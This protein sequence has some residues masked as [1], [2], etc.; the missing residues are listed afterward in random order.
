MRTSSISLGLAI[1]AATVLAQQT[2][3]SAPFDLVLSS[4]NSTINGSVL[5][6]CHEGAAIESLCLGGNVAD[7]YDQYNF[8][9]SSQS[10]PDPAL[11]V[12]G[13]LVRTFPLREHRKAR[14][15][16]CGPSLRS[17]P[18]KGMQIDDSIAFNL[19]PSV[20]G[21][22]LTVFKDLGVARWKLQPLVSNGTQHQRDQ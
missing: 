17:L 16:S 11:G 14:C 1:A 4:S 22:I 21:K 5:E 15:S 12:I 7:V 8:N 20:G 10:T 3:Q 18:C 19:H 2:N 13:V 9:F 6:S